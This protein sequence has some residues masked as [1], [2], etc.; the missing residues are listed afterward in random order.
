MSPLDVFLIFLEIISLLNLY[1]VF[2]TYG[3]NKKFISLI[4]TVVWSTFN[5][6]FI[7]YGMYSFIYNYNVSF[8]INDVIGY[9]GFS[10]FVIMIGIKDHL[11]KELT[12]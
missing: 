4:H 2:A 7:L 9:V 11:K 6:P 3:T 10:V 8:T 1:V 5:I 12:N